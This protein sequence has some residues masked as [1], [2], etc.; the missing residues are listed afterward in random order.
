MAE[1]EYNN[2]MENLYVRG[3]SEDYRRLPESIDQLKQGKGQIRT[4]VD[5]E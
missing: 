2:L 5:D 1:A 4:L 3:N